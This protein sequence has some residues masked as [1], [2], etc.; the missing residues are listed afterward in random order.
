MHVI[1]LTTEPEWSRSSNSYGYWQGKTYTHH[2]ER[3]PMTDPEITGETKVYKS[4]KRAVNMAEKL[5]VRCPYV[6]DFRVESY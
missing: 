2:G 5:I 6:V 4:K 3:F 1:Y